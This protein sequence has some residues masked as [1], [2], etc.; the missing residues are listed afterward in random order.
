MKTLKLK[1]GS[2]MPILGFGTWQLKGDE[3]YNAVSFALQTG[4]RHIDTA[5]AYENHK[6]IGLAQN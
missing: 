6:K 4:Y 2:H 5:A 3:A 1:N